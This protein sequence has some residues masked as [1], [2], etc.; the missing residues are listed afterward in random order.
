VVVIDVFETGGL[1]ALG[2]VEQAPQSEIFPIG[3][4]ILDNQAEELLVGEIGQIGM[5]DFITEACGH[6]EELER[7]KG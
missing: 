6:A 4:F 1:L 2:V 3:F 7:V 5:S